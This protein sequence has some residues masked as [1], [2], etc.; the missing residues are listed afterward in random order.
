MIIYEPQQLIEKEKNGRVDAEKKYSLSLVSGPDG[1]CLKTDIDLTKEEFSCRM[2]DTELLG[3]A[4][5]PEQYYENPDGTPIT[6]DR[7]YFDLKREDSILPGPFS[8]KTLNGLLL[9]K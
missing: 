9:S 4:F 7:D 2:V 3:M 5:E 6:F 8:S 1:I